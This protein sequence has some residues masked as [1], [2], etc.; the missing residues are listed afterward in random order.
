MATTGGDDRILVGLTE[1]Y[2][3]ARRH[4]MFWAS[5]LLVWELIGVDLAA[6]KTGSGDWADVARA[7]ASPSLLP[8][9]LNVFVLYAVLRLLIEWVQCPATSRALTAAKLDQGMALVV[10]GLSITIS[11]GSRWLPG[12]ARAVLQAMP[13][14][15]PRAALGLSERVTYAL[16]GGVA[17]LLLFTLGRRLLRLVA[18]ESTKR[19]SGLAVAVLYN[20]WQDTRTAIES[21]AA[22]AASRFTAAG[23]PPPADQAQSVRDQL[24]EI[25]AQTVEA[26][27]RIESMASDG[28]R[29]EAES[30]FWSVYFKLLRLDTQWRRDGTTGLNTKQEA[31]TVQDSSAGVPP[32]NGGSGLDARGG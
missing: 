22:E 8:L 15:P 6:L 26:M 10:A 29:E 23:I 27:R 13:E 28:N 4:L 32:P 25:N 1:H 14:W 17:G 31:P 24:A 20:Q 11:I 9:V 2:H 5:A 12:L 19:W 30:V 3:R 7:V 21:R 16:G 18:I